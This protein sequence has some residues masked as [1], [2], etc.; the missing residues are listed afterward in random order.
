MPNANPFML[1]HKGLTVT[2]RRDR[3]SDRHTSLQERLLRDA[4]QHAS[5]REVC[6]F[7]FMYQQ[8]HVLM[9]GF[10]SPVVGQS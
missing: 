4:T 7:V 5:S 10:S 1:F 8:V 3:G 9:I 2:G 6:S